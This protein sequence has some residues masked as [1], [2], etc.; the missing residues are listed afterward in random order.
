MLTPAQANHFAALVR[1]D[2]RIKP[3]DRLR[4]AK[5]LALN[6]TSTGTYR[7][8]HS[9]RPLWIHPV[10]GPH[11]GAPLEHAGPRMQTL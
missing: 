3:V 6:F 8:T 5:W 9:E 2:P 7:G 4:A 11:R 1:N 10:R